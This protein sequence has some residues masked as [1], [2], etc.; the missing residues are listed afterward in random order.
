LFI[1]NLKIKKKPCCNLGLTFSQIWL[2]PLLDDRH[3]GLKKNSSSSS[4]SEEEE[5]TVDTAP[6]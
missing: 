1:K 5:A 4:S 2:N 3:L 6:L